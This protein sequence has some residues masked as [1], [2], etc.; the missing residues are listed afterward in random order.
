MII[1]SLNVG[2]PAKELFFGKELIT[3]ICKKSALPRPIP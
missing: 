2:L 3:G 1:Q